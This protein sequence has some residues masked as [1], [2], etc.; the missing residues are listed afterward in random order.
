MSLYLQLEKSDEAYTI[1]FVINKT[2]LGDSSWC[3]EGTAI[4]LWEKGHHKLLDFVSTL[5]LTVNRLSR[6][7]YFKQIKGFGKMPEACLTF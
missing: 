7:F 5:H 2:F 3:I 1:P 4:T 6:N